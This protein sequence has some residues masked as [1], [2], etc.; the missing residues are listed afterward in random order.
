MEITLACCVML[1]LLF[2][3]AEIPVLVHDSCKACQISSG[4]ANSERMEVGLEQEEE[5]VCRKLQTKLVN[6]QQHTSKHSKVE[7]KDFC[8]FSKILLKLEPVHIPV[9]EEL[10][11]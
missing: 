1:L 10:T 11:N 8:Y 6:S 9:F 7:H 4:N 3:S 5:R 2:P